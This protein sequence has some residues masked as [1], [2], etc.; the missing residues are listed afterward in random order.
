MKPKNPRW[1]RQFLEIIFCNNATPRRSR[2][3]MYMRSSQRIVDI[4]ECLI[5]PGGIE[6]KNVVDVSLL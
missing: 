5:E 6:N 1:K 3:E 4:L 2:S